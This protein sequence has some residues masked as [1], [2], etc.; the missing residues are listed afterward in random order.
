[1]YNNKKPHNS[2]R[3]AKLRTV[4]KLST[5]YT[6]CTTSEHNFFWGGHG[7]GLKVLAI[8]TVQRDGT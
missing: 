1:M 2:S 8:L 3:F 7:E 6:P 4:S 5:F